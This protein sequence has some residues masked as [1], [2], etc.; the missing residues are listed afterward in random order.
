MLLS[1]GFSP[2][3]NDT[4][5]FDALVNHKIDTMGYQFDYQMQDVET[6]NEWAM[7]QKLAITKMSFA[8]SCFLQNNYTLLK[9]GA[10]MGKGVG[11]LLIGKPPVASHFKFPLQENAAANITVAL[12]GK[13]TT[14]N[15]LFQFFNPAHVKKI[16]MPFHTIEDWVLAA[17]TNAHRMGVIIHENRFTYAYK[18]LVAVQDLGAFWETK[19]KLP[20]PLGGIFIRENYDEK[21]KKDI[22]F[23]LEKSIQ[24]A[25]DHYSDALPDFVKSNARAMEEKIMWQ[26]IRLYVNAYSKSIGA[27]GE[28]AIQLMKNLLQGNHME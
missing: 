12:P 7:Q 23:L 27:E 8:A 2:C 9:A 18:G 19:T 24:Y 1:L 15:F 26:H 17:D 13:L 21:V 6:L 11:P 4:F 3:P 5:I 14:A 10:A 25:W 20:I 28:K 22:N 16:Y